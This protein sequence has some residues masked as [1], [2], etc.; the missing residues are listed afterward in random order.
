MLNNIIDV[1]MKLIF[2]IGS[3]RILIHIFVIIVYRL[4]N[5]EKEVNL[6]N[7]L[8]SICLYFLSIYYFINYI[9]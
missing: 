2:W 1:F 6:N 7:S 3:L 8:S 5:S 4:T 9:L